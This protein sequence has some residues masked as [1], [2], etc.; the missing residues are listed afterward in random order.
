MQQSVDEHYKASVKKGC[1]NSQLCCWTHNSYKNFDKDGGSDVAICL[2]EKALVKE[3]WLDLSDYK[4][5]EAS[6]INMA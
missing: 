4:M 3:G 5:E 6:L 1:G 2:L